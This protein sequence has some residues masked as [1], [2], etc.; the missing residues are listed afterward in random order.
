MMKGGEEGGQKAPRWGRGSGGAGG[1]ELGAK[2]RAHARAARSW[3]PW[4]RSEGKVGAELTGLGLNSPHKGQ[5][6]ALAD[7]REC[8]TR[9]SCG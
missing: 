7:E 4:A 9:R 2:P 8:S 1:R 5:Q 6:V 3:E